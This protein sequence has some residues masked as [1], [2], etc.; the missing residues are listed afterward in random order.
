MKKAENEKAEKLLAELNE[1][2]LTKKL[3]EEKAAEVLETR[4]GLRQRL[5]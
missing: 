4:R 5:K 3:R 2:P 1:H